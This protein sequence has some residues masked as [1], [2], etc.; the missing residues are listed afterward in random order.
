V[1]AHG[2]DGLPPAGLNAEKVGWFEKLSATGDLGLTLVLLAG[3]AAAILFDWR[4][5]AL[6]A[7]AAVVGSI[8]LH[9]LQGIV[10]YRRVMRR[11][12]PQVAP[13]EDDDD[14]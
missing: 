4:A 14:D 8:A 3:A 5:G 12:W 9:V 6:I 13:L 10:S 1:T 7:A 2:G 11:P